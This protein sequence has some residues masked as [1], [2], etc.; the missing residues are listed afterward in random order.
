MADRI[1]G[2]HPDV[3]EAIM[4]ELL[5]L[6]TPDFSDVIPPST[7]EALSSRPNPHDP[8]QGKLGVP[9]LPPKGMR[10]EVDNLVAEFRDRM[11]ELLDVSHTGTG[12]PAPP[13]AGPVLTPSP[14]AQLTDIVLEGIEPEFPDLGSVAQKGDG[15]NKFS[16]FL[17]SP[18]AALL[19]QIVS[20]LGQGLLS[21]PSEEERELARARSQSLGVGSAN[22]NSETF[23]QLMQLLL[24]SSGR[25]GL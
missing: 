2:V 22:Q 9:Q 21:R 13:N 14:P 20:G 12:V 18:G 3:L 15:G 19:G 4:R 5:G 8:V 1:A 23:Q 24:R 25:G 6:S 7:G 10:D 16:E 17:S 11:S